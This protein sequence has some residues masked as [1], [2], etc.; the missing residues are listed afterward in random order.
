M[1]RKIKTFTGDQ[2]TITSNRLRI[3]IVLRP[4]P[5]CG[6]VVWALIREID[7]IGIRERACRYNAMAKHV[8]ERAQAHPNLEFVQDPRCPFVVFA[9]SAK[10]GKI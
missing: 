9:M 1:Y 3:I 8:A 2:N 6:A 5:S 4:L 10:S 7:K